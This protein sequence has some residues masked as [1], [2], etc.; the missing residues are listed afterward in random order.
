M[1]K[2]NLIDGKVDRSYRKSWLWVFLCTAAIYTTIP[3]ARSAQKFISNSVGREFFTYAS[4]TTIISVFVLLIYILITK[5]KIRNIAQYIWLTLS[6][7]LFIYFTIKLNKYPEEALHLIEYGL[8]A[9][10]VFNALSHKIKDW[11]VYINTVLIVLMIGTCDEL[12]QWIIPS[13]VGSY[14]D[15]K[16]NTLAGLISTLAI[17][18]GVRPAAINQP[19]TKH[20]KRVLIKTII[21]TLIVLGI[22]LILLLPDP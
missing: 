16:I 13:R 2:H 12:I 8:L 14:A 7:S 10:F 5:L 6:A 20:S 19:V 15:V 3:L 11:T 4:L 21:L 1:N 18:Q 22:S 17:S 9:C